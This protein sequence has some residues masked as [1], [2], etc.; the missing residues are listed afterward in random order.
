MEKTII[1]DVKKLC[2]VGTSLLSIEL[3]YNQ[4]VHW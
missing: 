1:F 4:N 3:E 2:R